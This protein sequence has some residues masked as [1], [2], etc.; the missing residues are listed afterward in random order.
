MARRFAPSRRAFLKTGLAATAAVAA[1]GRLTAQTAPPAAKT[2]RAVMQG[3]L[4][5]LDPIWTTANI[6][7]YHGAMI[8]DTLFALDANLRPQPQMVGKWGLSDDKLT[9][10][11]E[12]RDGLKFYR[13]RGRDRRRRGRL[14]APLGGARRRR[15]AHDAAR[16]GHRRRRTTRPSPSR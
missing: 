7:A 15:P 4:R 6:T 13:R 11:F 3:D 8:Y 5:V 9:Y 1:P 12:L 2:I 14:D 16:E 10:T